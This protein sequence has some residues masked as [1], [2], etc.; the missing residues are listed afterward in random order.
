MHQADQNQ[1]PGD[2][3]EL[4]K[5]KDQPLTAAVLVVIILISTWAIIRNLG[6][7]KEAVKSDLS[8]LTDV[9]TVYAAVF[10]GAYFVFR[11]FFQKTFQRLSA[12]LAVRPIPGAGGGKATPRYMLECKIENKS[13]V[14][15][16]FN[17]IYYFAGNDIPR[18]DASESKYGAQAEYE[19][20]KAHIEGH[21]FEWNL[22][23]SRWR[24][25]V[26]AGSTVRFCAF[27][28]SFPPDGRVQVRFNPDLTDEIYVVNG[29]FVKPELSPPR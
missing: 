22:C 6:F 5:I 24:Y 27:L 7:T 14:R 11:F 21:S 2:T 15:I 4:S 16:N 23:S 20:K 25:S 9:A 19:A 1:P 3:D 17:R 29:C 28:D 26:D 10:A 18:V 13:E 12:E 8:I